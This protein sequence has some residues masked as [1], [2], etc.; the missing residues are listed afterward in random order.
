QGLRGPATSG[1]E[2]RRSAHSGSRCRSYQATYSSTIARVA[3]CVVTSST[4]PS[5]RTQ[6]RRPSHNAAR[7]S[8][9]VLMGGTG[10]GLLYPASRQRNVSPARN[11]INDVSGSPIFSGTAKG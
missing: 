10:L 4:K 2:K 6:T 9:P 5:P 3:G 7:Y 1:G 11:G 8:A